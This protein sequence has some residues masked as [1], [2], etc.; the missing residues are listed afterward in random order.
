MTS[1]KPFIFRMTPYTARLEEAEGG[2]SS[3]GTAAESNA[4]D[5]SGENVAEK[6]HTKDD[7]GQ[8]DAEREEDERKLETGIEISENERDR[9]SGHRVAGGERELVWR[10]NLGP[11]MRLDLART[12]ALTEALERFKDEDADDGGEGGR[13]DGGVALRATEDKDENGRGIPDPAIAKTSG[14]NHPVA[15][16]PGRAPT[17]EA[18]HH[19]VIAVLDETPE[20]AGYCHSATS[21]FL[22]P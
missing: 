5:D 14:H 21:L 15:N 17:V 20:I 12:R 18:A 9:R 22:A 19:T 16:P 3:K 10:Q 2:E 13:S 6:M 1:Q 7:A 4:K 8:R 11:A